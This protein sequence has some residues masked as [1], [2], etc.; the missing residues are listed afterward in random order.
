M[1]VEK[2]NND[3]HNAQQY[4]FYTLEQA[5]DSEGNAVK[6]RKLVETSTLE[7]L[8]NRESTLQNQ[9]DLVK[10]QIAEIKNL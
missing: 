9:L 5:I 2:Q 8:Q 10:K 4:N 7:Q 3:I 6:V 1:I